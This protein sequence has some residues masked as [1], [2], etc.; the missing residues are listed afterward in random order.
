MIGYWTEKASPTQMQ[1]TDQKKMS[2]QQV[3]H[4]SKSVSDRWTDITSHR[5]ATAAFKK[6]K[7]LKA[8]ERQKKNLSTLSTNPPS[9]WGG[10]EE[11]KE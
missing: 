7:V 1:Q 6:T 3:L 5:D 10:R 11:K 4:F 8:R 2:F 9:T